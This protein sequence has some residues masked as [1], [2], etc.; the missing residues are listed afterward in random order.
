MT[1]QKNLPPA[2]QDAMRQVGGGGNQGDETAAAKE[3]EKSSNGKHAAGEVAVAS[4]DFD[5]VSLAES[6]TIE[7]PLVT[8]IPAKVYLVKQIEARLTQRQRE[9]FYRLRA[10]LEKSGEKLESGR[11]VDT[12]SAVIQWLLESVG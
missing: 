5:E 9:N 4:V 2:V 8:A 10:G 12:N 11:K 1:K 6:V 3:K 7:L